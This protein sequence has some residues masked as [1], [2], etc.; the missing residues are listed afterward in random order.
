[1]RGIDLHFVLCLHGLC[2]D[3]VTVYTPL[4]PEGNTA[5]VANPFLP[6]SMYLVSEL[7]TCKHD[8]RLTSWSCTSREVRPS[9]RSDR[10]QRSRASVVAFDPLHL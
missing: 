7:P 9:V 8:N 3:K 1:M 10:S 4:P 2:R 5:I 6:C